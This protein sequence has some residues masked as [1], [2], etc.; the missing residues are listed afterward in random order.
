MFEHIKWTHNAN[1]FQM[2]VEFRPELFYWR[3]L[4]PKQCPIF[5]SVCQ[6][7][8]HVW[9]S[10]YRIYTDS[11]LYL[12]IC[13]YIHILL[14]CVAAADADIACL[15]HHPH[16]NYSNV[17]HI[18]TPNL[19]LAGGCPF[20]Q[21]YLITQ[22]TRSSHRDIHIYIHIYIYIYI[23]ACMLSCKG[24]NRDPFQNMITYLCRRQRRR[25]LVQ[26]VAVLLPA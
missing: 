23:Y 14:L 10:R 6:Y 2:A 19:G 13:I 20:F 5:V 21:L 12:S 1:P 15:L 24:C 11:I 9:Y 4:W 18:F 22:Q 16:K 7:V 25:R 8:Y 17:I 26:M 3:D